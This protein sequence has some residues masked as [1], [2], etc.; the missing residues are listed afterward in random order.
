MSIQ[1][2]ANA[3]GISRTTADRYWSYAKVFL[4]CAIEDARKI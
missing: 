2:A 1:E 4:Y 3:L